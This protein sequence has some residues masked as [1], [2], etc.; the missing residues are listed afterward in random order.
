MIPNMI[1]GTIR[2]FTADLDEYY[3][4]TYFLAFHK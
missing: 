4:I 3:G 2:Y 1:P